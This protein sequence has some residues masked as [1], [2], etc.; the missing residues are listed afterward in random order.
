MGL[1]AKARCSGRADA[2]DG[3]WVLEPP[4]PMPAP[5]AAADLRSAATCL[6]MYPA[7]ACTQQAN[8]TMAMWT[9]CRACKQ[10]PTRHACYHPCPNK[11]CMLPAQHACTCKSQ[12]CSRLVACSCQQAALEPTKGGSSSGRSGF[13][14]HCLA[15]LTSCVPLL[16]SE[17]SSAHPR[18][19]LAFRLS[20]WKARSA[21]PRPRR[22]S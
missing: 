17:E 21:L 22:A 10:L 18:A 15:G 9:V 20:E 12:A 19:L 7:H 16:M 2:V 13:K 4:A 8:V 1:A 11:A 5:A 3:P 14:T 6:A